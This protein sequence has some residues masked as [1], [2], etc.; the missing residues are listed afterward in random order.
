MKKPLRTLVLHPADVTTDF[1]KPIYQNMDCTV[2]TE[3][4]TDHTLKMYIRSHDRIIMLGHG[5]PGGLYGHNRVMINSTHVEFLKDKQLIGIWCFANKFFET[6]G[7]LGIY[8]GM[9]ISEPMEAVVFNVP[10]THQNINESNTLFTKAV[11]QSITSTTPI[12]VFRNM[13]RS[14]S[15]P[16][17]IY[18]QDNFFHAY[19][20]YQI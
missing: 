4:I 11:T 8:S 17:M 13:Y 3:D 6:H 19:P 15:N 1:L 5:F 7:L 16:V 14:D 9:I 12:E 10:Y 18:N 2:I 20:V